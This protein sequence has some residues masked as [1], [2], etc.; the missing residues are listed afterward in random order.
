MIFLPYSF[1][2]SASGPVFNKVILIIAG[3]SE[4][5]RINVSIFFPRP[6]SLA[7]DP[8]PSCNACTKADLPT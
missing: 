3:P 4:P 5:S 2:L 8:N 6:V 1:G 7:F